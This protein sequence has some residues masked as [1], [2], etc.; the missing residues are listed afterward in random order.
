[1]SGN[2]VGSRILERVEWVR[3]L[4]AELKRFM[5]RIIA[6]NFAI[7]REI[8]ALRSA[9]TTRVGHSLCEDPFILE[10]AIGRTAPVHLRFINSWQAFDAVME[11]RFKGKQGLPKIQRKEYILEEDATGL[12]IDRS[13]DFSDCFLPGQK[14]VMSLVFKNES[15]FPGPPLVTLCPRCQAPSANPGDSNILW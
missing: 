8:V 11:I 9:F 5:S 15:A 2:T 3:N 13:I 12:E 14:I 6:G 7:Y 4:G 1:M 10:D